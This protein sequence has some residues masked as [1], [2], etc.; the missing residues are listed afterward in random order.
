[1]MRYLKVTGGIRG[2]NQKVLGGI[3]RHERPESGGIRRYQEILGF[4]EIGIQA[5]PPLPSQ[6]PCYLCFNV[7]N[8]Y[9]TLQ[10]PVPG[11]TK[12]SPS[13]P[14]SGA[15]F[16]SRYISQYSELGLATDTYT[17]IRSQFQ[18]QVH[19]PVSGARFSLRY[20]HQYPEL[21]SAPGT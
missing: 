6:S 18:L 4:H 3:R 12:P 8:V 19:I 21:G 7:F 11:Y 20:I 16:R 13:T 17:S 15:M 1:M 10:Y 14:V 5:P 2:R 9:T